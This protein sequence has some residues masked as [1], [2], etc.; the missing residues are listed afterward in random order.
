MSER[1]DFKFINSEF[2]KLKDVNIKNAELLNKPNNFNVG[3]TVIFNNR[4]YTILDINLEKKLYKL[5]QH[6]YVGFTTIHGAME[7]HNG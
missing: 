5:D 3:D 1:V 4:K 2:E 7:T 6:F